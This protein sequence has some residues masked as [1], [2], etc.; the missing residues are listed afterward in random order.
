MKTRASSHD[1][2][3][4]LVAIPN[5]H[6]CIA[7][8]GASTIVGPPKFK[9]PQKRHNGWLLNKQPDVR[10]KTN[11]KKQTHERVIVLKFSS[12]VQYVPLPEVPKKSAHEIQQPVTA[13]P[14][15]SHDGNEVPPSP[16][17]EVILTYIPEVQV[18]H[19]P[20][21]C[22]LNLM[23]TSTGNPLLILPQSLCLRLKYWLTCLLRSERKESVRSK[24]MM[25]LRNVSTTLSKAKKN[26]PLMSTFLMILI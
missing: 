20:L 15:N 18:Q 8:K 21:I 23:S 25:L 3:S 22:L 4:S 19:L 1:A 14:H 16:L 13:A 12:E 7:D 2:P 5:P 11:K 26:L 10:Q 9:V 24:R 6:V 17:P